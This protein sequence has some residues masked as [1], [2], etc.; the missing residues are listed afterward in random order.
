MR[1]EV[2]APDETVNL[3]PDRLEQALRN[4]LE[5]AIRHAPRGSVVRLSADRQDGTTRFVV[6][7]QGPGFRPDLLSRAFEPF[8]RT[9]GRDGARCP[10]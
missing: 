5:N 6:N 2:D 10:R 8:V 3:D 4:L 9:R 1:I 7:D